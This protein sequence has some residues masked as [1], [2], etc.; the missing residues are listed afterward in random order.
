[1][2]NIDNQIL[3]EFQSESKILINKMTSILNRCEGDLSQVQSLEDYGQSVDRIMGAAKSLALL[4]PPEHLI[5]KIADY[6]AICKA[7]GYKSAQIKNNEQ[8]YDICVALLADGTE[9]L[10]AL[11]QG[12]SQP[13]EIKDLFSKTFLDRLRWVSNEF[14]TEFRSSLDVH[15]GQKNKLSQNEIDELLKKLGFD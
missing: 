2:A 12:L 8:F 10:Q 1:M 9:V 15:K 3:K 11:I 5:H 13:V 4:A 14:G 6:S 7:V